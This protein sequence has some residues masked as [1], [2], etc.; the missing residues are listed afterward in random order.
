MVIGILS[1]A[2]VEVT[3]RVVL[4]VTE[5]VVT[6]NVVAVVVSVVTCLITAVVAGV[7]IVAGR[8]SCNCTGYCQTL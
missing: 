4:C 5:T 3:D 8:C 6:S 1:V 7:V 2:V